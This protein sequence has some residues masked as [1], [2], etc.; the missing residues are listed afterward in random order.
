[1]NKLRQEDICVNKSSLS[2]RVHC[3]QYWGVKREIAKCQL[4]PLIHTFLKFNLAQDVEKK[5]AE[6]K[7]QLLLSLDQDIVAWSQ[8][9]E[10]GL[11]YVIHAPGRSVEKESSRFRNLIPAVNKASA[12][13]ALS[14]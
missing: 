9:Q 8:G 4:H 11:K 13:S 5:R 14:P 6:R 12:C 10:C 1:M 3:C 2:S 7:T